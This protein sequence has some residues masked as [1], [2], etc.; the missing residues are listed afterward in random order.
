M[1]RRSLFALAAAAGLVI[2]SVPLFA[3]HSNAAFDAGKR[4]T[5]TGTVTEWFWANPHCLLS[6]DVKGADGQ[7]VRWV[8]ETQAPPN[9]IPFGWSK[10]SFKPGEVVTI[11]AEPARTGKPVGRLLRAV[12]ADGRTLLPG[13]SAGAA[14]A[15]GGNQP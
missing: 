13:G 15:A 14:A 9:M 4:V 5:I 11:T 2:A 10:Q 6:L 8:V 1:R 3:H 7:V 12:F